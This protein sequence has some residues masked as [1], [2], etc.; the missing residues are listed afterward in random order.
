[1]RVQAVSDHHRTAAAADERKRKSQNNRRVRT[2]AMPRDRN[3]AADSRPWS[4][5]PV[6]RHHR[7]NVGRYGKL[8]TALD[9]N[10]SLAIVAGAAGWRSVQTSPGAG[11]PDK[12]EMKMA[13]GQEHQ[14]RC[15]YECQYGA[16]RGDLPFQAAQSRNK[17]GGR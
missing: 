3:E 15:Y 5:S 7:N 12:A 8:R 6:S 16:D 4:T 9:G 14:N 1:M 17:T 10:Q 13:S 2:A 11:V